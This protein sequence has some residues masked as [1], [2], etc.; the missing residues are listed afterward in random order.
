MSSPIQILFNENIN[1]FLQSF[2]NPLIDKLFVAITNSGTHPVYFIIAS[3]LYWCY[4]KKTG[5]RAM[6]VILFSA[7]FAIFAKN[8]FAMPRPPEHLHKI[9]IEGFGLPSA[10]AQV[11]AGFWGYMGGMTRDRKMILIG[12]LAIILMAFSRVY[13][14][15][16]FVGDVMAG[17]FF[18][19]LIAI[20]SLRSESFFLEKGLD[21]GKKYAIAVMLPAILIIIA[22]FFGFILEQIL[23]LWLVMVSI[24]AGYIMEEEG[25]GLKD[26]KNNRQRI[27]RAFVGLML[28]AFVYIIFYPVSGIK[29]TEG[30]KYAVL[31]LTSTFAAP[32]I[33]ARM[34]REL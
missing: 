3:I 19:L 13:L 10:H 22:W 20:L 7:F 11:S 27:K 8:I 25:V 33:F 9:A 12:I 23:E 18:G 31:G 21:R 2:G 14:G 32:W 1:V 30:I 5:I 26:A 34:E 28:A 15:V 6:Y 16:H 29:F 24:G 17:I 4:G